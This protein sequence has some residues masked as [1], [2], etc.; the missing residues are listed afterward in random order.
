MSELASN[1][2]ASPAGRVKANQVLAVMSGGLA[3]VVAAAAMLNVGLPD[4]TRATGATQTNALWI[5]NAYSLVFAA[6]LLPA[7]ALGDLIGRRRTFIAG[8]VLFGGFSVATALSTDPTTL[9]VLRGL[10]GVGAALVM[11]VSLTIITAT[12][13]ASERGRAVGV[14]SGVAGGA[15]T[16]G[17]IIAGL[18]LE[19]F[20]WTSIFWLSA[21]VSV[22][23]LAAT[24]AFVPES[25]ERRAPPLD[26]PGAL[27]SVI[28][29]G[30]LVYTI[31]E[32]PQNGW[33]N[34]TVLAS[35]I[36]GVLGLTAFIILELR[37]DQPMLDPRLFRGRALGT[38]SLS[39]ALQFAASFGLFVIIFEYLQ[40]SL[41]YSTLAAGLAVVPQGLGIMVTA[42]LSDRA[43]R[44]LGLGAT[45]GIGL[46]LL[47]GGFAL[48]AIMTAAGSSYWALL[49]GLIVAG[50]GLGL[51]SAAATTSILSG[52]PRH[53]RGSA[54]GVNNA[55]RE[56]GGA[57]GIAAMGSL[58]NSTYSSNVD[59]HGLAAGQAHTASGS[60]V[61]AQ[62]VASTL[63][64]RGQDLV[65]SAQG[66]FVD[67]FHAAL[68]LAV[69]VLGLAA[70]ILFVVG[71]R[72]GQIALE[73]DAPGPEDD[74]PTPALDSDPEPLP[75]G[76][77]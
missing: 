21:V 1:A 42:I 58:L 23:T 14:W 35:L 11:P 34:P 76:A 53:A 15:G 61:G 38:G 19:V 39:V 18:L 71:P 16:L 73:S 47:A 66:A 25:R 29:L 59:V 57:I 7:S 33:G 75:V 44:K 24:V 2:N 5:V 3:V 51:S 70:A 20:D 9:I 41:G 64:A 27:T 48:L 8:L 4:L 72:P 62:Q 49:P 77:H 10:A 67:G 31:I 63:G 56:I 37:R 54:S 69:V 55:A 74:L 13:P 30:G 32:Q 60:I 45:G 6:L 65:L 68:W 46:A 40:F 52:A 28:G 36:A 43:A 26:L 22:L 50:A 12:F 17:L